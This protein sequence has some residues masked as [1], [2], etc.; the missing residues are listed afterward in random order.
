[1][2]KI[3]VSYAFWVLYVRIEDTAE[4]LSVFQVYC[5]NNS[6]CWGVTA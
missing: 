5:T 2:G 6:Q 3:K 4:N 1:M